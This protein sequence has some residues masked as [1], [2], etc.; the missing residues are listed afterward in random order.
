[1]AS[2]LTASRGPDAPGPSRSRPARPMLWL[3]A[4]GALYVAAQ[5]MW[6]GLSF[7]LGWD[8][9]VYTSQVSATAPPLFW[10]APRARGVPALIAPVVH[11]TSSVPALRLY[12][13][14]L[15][16]VGL[17]LAFRPWLR[18]RAGYVVSVGAAAFGSLWITVFYG[19]EAMPNLPAALLVVAG[20]GYGVRALGGEPT[21]TPVP[22]LFGCF[23]GLS[24][25]RPTDALY[26]AAPLVVLAVTRRRVRVLAALLGGLAVG[27]GAWA[28]E[29]QLRFGGVLA[30][31]A[32]ARAEDAGGVH[33]NVL[34]F[35]RTL[36]GPIECCASVPSGSWPHAVAAGLWWPAAI[37]LA[38]TGL[39]AADRARRSAYLTAVV[40]AALLGVQY[41]V[42]LN[43]VGVRHLLPVYALVALPV[44]EGICRVA[45]AARR[46]PA[47]GVVLAGVALLAAAQLVSQ[48]MF[49]RENV[50]QG[51][52]GRA[53]AVVV[54]TELHRLGVVPPCVLT[55]PGVPPY[56]YAAA[57]RQVSADIDLDRS[58]AAQLAAFARPGTKVAV[59]LRGHAPQAR[60]L[61]L[62]WTEHRLRLGR[63]TWV[64]L[65][66]PADR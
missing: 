20:A 55:G 39:A 57:C 56:A 27:W 38:V 24:L 30:R 8:E 43:V 42:V 36:G 22:A 45:T 16:G 29:A 3:T 35:Y 63:L 58:T 46:R 15:G 47:G 64:I 5:L 12:L 62:G 49:L 59:V 61:L 44:G 7:G 25:V 21:R 41:F 9:S 50:E 23:A 60:A 2:A 54:A 32:Q 18:I 10:S 26:L 1:M 48:V 53:A 37:A 33:A 19:N 51:E 13:T 34:L 52:Q 40:M 14:L 17:V 4:V 28:L 6:V 65:T 11:L 31:L 66:P